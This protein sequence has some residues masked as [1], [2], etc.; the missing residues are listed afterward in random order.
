MKCD[1]DTN[2]NF[3][4]PVFSHMMENFDTTGAVAKLTNTADTG[5]C[6]RFFSET[7]GPLKLGGRARSQRR[8]YHAPLA[9]GSGNHERK[10][11]VTEGHPT[12]CTAPFRPHTTTI[13][14]KLS[15]PAMQRLAT[16][17]NRRPPI[18]RCFGDRVSIC[19]KKG[20]RGR[21][22]ACEKIQ[23]KCREG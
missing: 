10:T 3:K 6:V 15:V 8:L 22:R 18:R 1:T 20:E 16:A 13:N 19:P 21:E 11:F 12:D 9:A 5:Y 23:K 17:D 2:N 7:D 14:G 4:L